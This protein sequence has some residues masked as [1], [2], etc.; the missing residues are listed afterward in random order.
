M[1]LS[2]CLVV[3]NEEK[4]IE[5][6]LESVKGLGDEIIL[7]HDG[8]CTDKTLDIA[9]RYTDKIFILPHKGDSSLHRI[10]TYEKAQGEWVFQIDADEYLDPDSIPKIRALIDAAEG[11]DINGYSFEW[12]MWNLKKAIFVKGFQKDCLFRRNHFH[13]LG[14][15]HG[16]AYIDGR[17]QSSGMRLHHRPAYDNTSWHSAWRKAKRWAPIHARFFFPDRVSFEGFNITPEKWIAFTEKVR[18]HTLRHMLWE[19]LKMFLGQMRNG[20]YTSIYGWK[21][22]M[23]LYVYYLYLYSLV[24]RMKKNPN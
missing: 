2:V 6:C 13:Y 15:T 5:Q 24:W 11:T 9:R 8:E 10:F 19:P 16:Y 1:K 7:V 20:L 18:A 17:T 4:I 14:I 3:Y 12:E 21:T 23:Q 22:A